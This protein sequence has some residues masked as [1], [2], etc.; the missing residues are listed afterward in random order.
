[1]IFSANIYVRKYRP[2]IGLLLLVSMLSTG[3]AAETSEPVVSPAQVDR[4]LSFISLRTLSGLSDPDEYY[5]DGRSALSYGKCQFK[6][7]PLSLLSFDSV[8][9][10]LRTGQLDLED[11]VIDLIGIR[12]LSDSVYWQAPVVK[13]AEH[14]PI[15]YL[16]GYNMNFVRSCKQASL[17]EQ[18]LG[19]NQRVILFSWPSDGVL[20]NYT[21][22]EADAQWSIHPLEQVLMQM[23]QH[24]GAGGFDVVAHSL[25]GRALLN[26]LSNLSG[27]KGPQPAMIDQLVLIAPDMD[28]G[29]FKQ[30]LPSIRP[31][32]ENISLYVSDN[33]K[34]LSLSEEVH[35][36]PRLGQAGV[37]LKQFD[38][39]EII[40]VSEVGISTFS[41][42]L[43]HLYHAQ[44]EADLRLLLNE[45]LTA[46]DRLTLAPAGESLWKL[47][48]LEE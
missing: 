7:D 23:Q 16:H 1:M 46:S 14:R 40:D 32:A 21:R 48:A 34:P 47:Q 20:T 3:G 15:L 12:Q 8:K 17:F 38:G 13:N 10:V 24:F 6:V 4:E 18:N 43:Y 5:A 33:D 25:G 35:G 44:V 42:H 2:G 30:L 19:I 9:S 26:A 27:R 31:M 11:D 36:Y 29:I 39:I 28:A 41:G 22:D 45:R 37:H